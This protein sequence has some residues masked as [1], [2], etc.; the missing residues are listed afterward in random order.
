M[1]TKKNNLEKDRR[2]KKGGGFQ[3]QRVTSKLKT[4]KYRKNIR[5][6]SQI[7]R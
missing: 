6:L 7:H 5:G 2:G 4:L 1:K 3:E